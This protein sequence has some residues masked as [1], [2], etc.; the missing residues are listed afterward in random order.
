MFETTKLYYSA[1]LL[2][3]V[4]IYSQ[5]TS[6]SS[7]S[8]LFVVYPLERNCSCL[9]IKTPQTAIERHFLGSGSRLLT[10][11]TS[12]PSNDPPLVVPKYDHLIRPTSSTAASTAATLWQHFG[13]P[14]NA[15]KRVLTRKCVI[16]IACSCALRHKAGD[17]ANLRAHLRDA[18]TELYGDLQTSKRGK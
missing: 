16:C 1:T 13:F 12:T 8:I 9:K 4:I 7:A 10:N 3:A 2:A 6:R 15:Q 11:M 14:A 18:H 17:E 5:P